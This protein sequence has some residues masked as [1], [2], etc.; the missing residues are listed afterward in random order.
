MRR[1]GCRIVTR[2]IH[3]WSVHMSRIAD[4]LVSRLAGLVWT[5]MYSGLCNRG[6]V[7][8][9]AQVSVDGETPSMSEQSPAIAA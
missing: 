4:R 3:I 1:A 6:S 5:A 7:H 9:V 2:E 8:T